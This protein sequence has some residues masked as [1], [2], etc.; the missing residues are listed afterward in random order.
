MAR[1]KTVTDQPLTFQ[2]KNIGVV[3]SPFREAEGTPIQPVYSG[4]AQFEVELLPEYVDGLRD[5]AGFER[6]WLLCWF[7]R[8]SAPRLRVVPFRDITERGV[9]A[10]R[11]P[12]RPVPIGLSCVRLLGIRGNVLICSGADILDGS[13]LLDIKPY[14]PECDAFL[15]SRAGWFDESESSRTRADDRF[16]S[17]AGRADKSEDSDE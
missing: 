16:E 14:I 8:A 1:S 13:P 15:G 12:S 9:F 17:S 10:T 11:A 7:D 3:H 2:A 6:I 5:L 4:D